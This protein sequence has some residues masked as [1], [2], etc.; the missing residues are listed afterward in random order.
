MKEAGTMI[1]WTSDESV[2]R[3]AVP[4]AYWIGRSDGNNVRIRSENKALSN[5]VAIDTFG[6]EPE[7][8][9]KAWACARLHPLPAVAA[10]DSAHRKVV[11][12]WPDA[13]GVQSSTEKWYCFSM[14]EGYRY[15]NGV[16]SDKQNAFESEAEAWLDAASRLE[17]QPAIETPAAKA[18][19]VE[20]PERVAD[21]KRAALGVPELVVTEEDTCI[22]FQEFPHN[23]IP[24]S[25]FACRERQLREA[26]AI[27]AQNRNNYLQEL[28]SM[29][30][31]RNDWMARAETAEASLTH[32]RA[33]S[34]DFLQ[35]VL[36][37]FS[38][39]RIEPVVVSGS[40]SGT[41]SATLRSLGW[42]AAGERG[43]L[44]QDEF[45]AKV[46][47]PNERKI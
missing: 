10:L 25:R 7:A 37:A 45:L 31:L 42:P 46:S 27:I 38:N 17:T 20:M 2:V 13:E 43:Y 32:L 11:E 26:Y 39:E 12:K 44:T 14:E 28:E 41:I 5:W 21:F 40:L 18:S 9:A 6:G 3:A 36:L 33:S 8:I 22:E 19:V 35:E 34:A 29:G 30:H 4:D 16:L 24:V 23:H 1:D 47:G 15:G